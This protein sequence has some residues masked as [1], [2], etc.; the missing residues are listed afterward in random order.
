MQK[1]NSK[2]QHIL[3][4]I[5]CGILLVTLNTNSFANL[6]ELH[7]RKQTEIPTQHPFSTGLISTKSGKNDIAI[8]NEI[9]GRVRTHFHLSPPTHSQRYHK[10]VKRLATSQSTVNALVKNAQPYLY[11]I[12]EEVENTLV[13]YSRKEITKH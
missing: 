2:F 12:L 9:W 3:K 7:P 4:C 1:L 10:H 5:G 8:S 13:S 11:Y 6:G